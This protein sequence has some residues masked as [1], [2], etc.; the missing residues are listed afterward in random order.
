MD[1]KW[2]RGLLIGFRPFS[3]T[4]TLTGVSRETLSGILRMLGLAGVSLTY[5]A[6]P[7]PKTEGP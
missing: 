1:G 3:N 4:M 6:F 7:H 5:S 2:L